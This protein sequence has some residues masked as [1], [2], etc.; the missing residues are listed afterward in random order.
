MHKVT[1]YHQKTMRNKNLQFS[2]NARGRYPKIVTPQYYENGTIR[3]IMY[4]ICK[5][6]RKHI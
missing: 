3:I 2:T 1:N 6:S 5:S 4:N